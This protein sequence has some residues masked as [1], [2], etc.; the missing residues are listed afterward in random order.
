[1][2]SSAIS[3]NVFLA[4]FGAVERTL[5]T[6]AGP[7]PSPLSPRF[8]FAVTPSY[9]ATMGIAVKAGRAFTVRD[10]A[11]SEPVAM[12]NE[13]MAAGAWPGASPLGRSVTLPDGRS[14]TVVGMSASVGGS[15]LSVR[16][17]PPPALY[18]PFDQMPGRPIAL[19]VRSATQ[20]LAI[21]PGMVEAVAALDPDEPVEG[22]RSTEELFETWLRPSR[23]AAVLMGGVAALAVLLGAIGLYGVVAYTVGQRTRE[24]G[25]RLAVGAT[26]RQ[27]LRLVLTQGVKVTVAGAACGVAGAVAVTRLLR[28]ILFGTDPLDP[29]VFAASVALLTT[30]MLAAV[31]AP[32]RRA[33]RVQP[34]V[35]L[36][37]E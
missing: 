16:Q 20:A 2:R 36:R 32:A 28:A 31:L 4:G 19:H 29:V 17:E 34:L 3:H 8:A 6:E 22:V 18:V 35:A 15:P 9:F 13:A 12:V 14:L 27:I 26:S 33:A 10:R 37:D 25:V 21:A 23:M 5:E 11:G 24:F 30:V 1:V 7:L